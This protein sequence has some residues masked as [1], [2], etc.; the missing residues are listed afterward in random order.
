[1]KGLKIIIISIILTLAT[2]TCIH[3]ETNQIKTFSVSVNPLKL[4]MGLINIGIEY[5]VTQ[6]CSIGLFT[7]YLAGDYAIKRTAHPDL[8]LR[9]EPRW[10]FNSE[11]EI[12]AGWYGGIN[13]GYTWSKNNPDYTDF[14]IEAETGYKLVYSNSFYLIPK[15]LLTYPLGKEQILPGAELLIGKL[16]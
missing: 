16:F 13:G 8:V 14:Y 11:N 10:Y 12:N 3:A 9:V 4:A 1:M 5:Q 15:V 2:A 7:E 6:S